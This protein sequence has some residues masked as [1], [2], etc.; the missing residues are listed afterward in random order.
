MAAIKVAWLRRMGWTSTRVDLLAGV[1]TTA[2]RLR[3][4][5]MEVDTEAP[6]SQRESRRNSA[7]TD[8]LRGSAK[9]TSSKVSANEDPLTLSNGNI[10]PTGPGTGKPVEGTIFQIE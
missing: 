6:L 3:R 1:S 9:I 5:R 2:L 8:K 4:E 7:P 10:E